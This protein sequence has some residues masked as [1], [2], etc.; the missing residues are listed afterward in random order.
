M[1]YGTERDDGGGG[2]AWM[3]AVIASKSF[4]CLYS[5]STVNSSHSTMPSE[6]RSLRAS[7][8]CPRACSGD[9]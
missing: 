8:L 1:L 7:T 6:N 3:I 4:S 2:G 5:R 9:R